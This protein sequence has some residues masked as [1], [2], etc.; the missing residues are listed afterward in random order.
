MGLKF[1]DV[2]KALA[3]LDG[4][5]GGNGAVD[6]GLNLPDRRLAASV[7]KRGDIEIFPRVVDDVARDG[8]GRLS[9]HVAEHIVELQVGNCQAILGAILLSR[10]HV[11]QLAEI[12][13]EIA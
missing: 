4:L 1:F 2:V 13:D 10:L 12:A 7:H 5:L 11:G 9:E 8:K 6:G 3:K